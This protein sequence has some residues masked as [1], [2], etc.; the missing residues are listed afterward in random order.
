[1]F[2]R[3]RAYAESLARSAWARPLHRFWLTGWGFDW[4]Y[5]RLFVR[6]VVWFARFDKDDLIDSLYQGIARL[7]E[8][9]HRLLSR[10]QNGRLR[11]YAM[12]ISAGAVVAIAIVVWL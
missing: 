6:P 5:D 1:M 4:L 9:C 10:T 12:G 8:R 3:Q 7:G 2:Q 11:W